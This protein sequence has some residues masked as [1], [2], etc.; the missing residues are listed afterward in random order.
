[1]IPDRLS[2]FARGDRGGNPAGVVIAETLPDAARMQAMAKEIGYSETAFAAPQDGGWRVRYFAP[3]AEVA[4]CGHATIALGAALGTRYGAG[5]FPLTLSRA[6]ISVTAEPSDGGWRAALQSPATRSG[7]L[8]D[9]LT[10]RLLD[11]FGLTADDL[12]PRLPPTLAFAGNDHPF[13]ALKDRAR[14]AAMA[15][16]F[17]AMRETMEKAGLT[18]VSLLHIAG[19][20]LFDARVAFAIGGVVEDPATGAAAAA[21]G[22]A[23]VDLGWPGLAGGGRFT[24]RQGDDMGQPSTLEVTV[25]GRAGDPVRVGGAVRSLGT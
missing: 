10:A 11:H 7:P 16:D 4:F 24:I 12:D 15:Y 23:L 19:E 14:L 2:A 25:T 3:E 1:M 17:E 22:G 13:I 6:S 21:L 5:T 18:T 8:S 9:A 20:A